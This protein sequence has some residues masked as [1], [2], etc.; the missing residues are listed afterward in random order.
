[1]SGS[2]SKRKNDRIVGTRSLPD[3]VN[4]GN[5]NQIF[6]THYFR[7]AHDQT[8][9]PTVLNHFS[10]GS[11]RT[12]SDNRSPSIGL[13]IPGQIGL[14]GVAQNHFPEFN[15][16]EDLAGIG[17]GERLNID[18]GLRLNDS[19]NRSRQPQLQDRR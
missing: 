12:V 16:G 18:N 2:Y 11:N 10:I 3:I 8:F 9:S 5:Q 7:L 14:T 15:F 1:M 19:V 17:F 6:T 13:G 4:R